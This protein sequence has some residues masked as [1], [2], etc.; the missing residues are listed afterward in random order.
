MKIQLH[1]IFFFLSIALF[2]LNSDLLATINCPATGGAGMI[3][4]LCQLGG[5]D[6]MGE[7]TVYVKLGNKTPEAA[8]ST[9]KGTDENG[10]K[11][12]CNFSCGG[13]ASK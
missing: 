5:P 9:C 4:C 13:G 8:C 11:W 6:P 10:L 3:P 12:T 7:T 2:A 1:K